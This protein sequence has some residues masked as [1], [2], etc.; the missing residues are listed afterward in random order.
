[1]CRHAIAVTLFFVVL[2]SGAL[3]AA[4][5]AYVTD[6]FKITF[7]SGPGTQHKI[8]SM[9]SSAQPVEILETQEE[10]SRVQV[11]NAGA[12]P[13]EGWVL[14]QYLIQRQP[15]QM[16]TEALTAGMSR[17]K[18]QVKTLREQVSVLEQNNRDLSQ[19]L[20]E[21]TRNLEAVTS[22]YR[23]LEQGSAEYLQVKKKLDAAVGR[24]QQVEA[25]YAVLDDTY[26]KLKYSQRNTW[27]AIGAGILLFGILFGMILGRREKRHRPRYS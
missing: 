18:D 11:A 20:G 22:D 6:T 27:F 17:L 2:F 7:R 3:N 19:K 23:T 12:E 5:P 10:W 25:D 9:L 4:Q 14:S 13:M 16:Q 21:K 24:L 8:I 15:W 1:M 26:K